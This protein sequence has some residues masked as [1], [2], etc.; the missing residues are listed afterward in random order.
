MPNVILLLSV[1]DSTYRENASVNVAI[2]VK[3]G[4]RIEDA[5]SKISHVIDKIAA[6]S[7]R[8]MWVMYG[9]KTNGRHKRIEL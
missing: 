3:I 8:L 2:C 9:I 5:K 6:N 4:S 7:F 1:Y